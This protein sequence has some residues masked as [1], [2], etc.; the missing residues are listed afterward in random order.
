MKRS[1]CQNSTTWQQRFLR[2]VSLTLVRALELN[3]TD[4]VLP[5][6]V[7]PIFFHRSPKRAKMGLQDCLFENCASTLFGGRSVVGMHRIPLPLKVFYQAFYPAGRQGIKG[8]GREPA[9]V[10]DLVF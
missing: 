9:I 10:G 1:A 2:A 3:P 5:D 4:N 8:V 7:H 6:Y